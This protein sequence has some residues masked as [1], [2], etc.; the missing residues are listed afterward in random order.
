[1]ARYGI[2]RGR[3]ARGDVFR[4]HP[5]PRP[6]RGR[7]RG[8]RCT[9]RCLPLR[10]FENRVYE[11]ELEDER[12]L[13]VKF[14]RPGRWSRETIL[15]EHA[16][17]AD[18]ADA[19]V[20]AVAPIDLGTGA[21]LSEIEGIFY[22]AFPKVRGRSLDEARRRRIA[23]GSA[24]RSAAC[25]RSAPRATR[26]AARGSTSKRYILEPLEVLMAG[27]FIPRRSRRATAMSPSGS[28]TAAVRPLAAARVQRIHGDLHW[29]NILWT[30][31]SAPGRLRRLSGRPARPG[32]LAPGARQF[33][34]GA[35]AR[36]RSAG[37]L[38]ALPR[39]RPLD[40][41][42][43]RAATRDAHRLHVGLDRATVERSVVSP[44]S[45]CSATTTTGTRSTRSS[46]RSRRGSPRANRARSAPGGQ[47]VDRVRPVMRTVSPGWAS[48]TTHCRAACDRAHSRTSGCRRS[49]ARSRLEM[50]FATVP[51]RRRSR[52]SR[53][54]PAAGAATGSGRVAPRAGTA[55]GRS[56][57]LEDRDDAR[58]ACLGRGDGRAWSFSPYVRSRRRPGCLASCRSPRSGWATTGNRAS[59][60]RHGRPV[61][62]ELDRHQR[63]G[64]GVL[65]VVQAGLWEIQGDVAAGV[66]QHAPGTRRPDAG[67][68]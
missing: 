62:A 64:G 59:E 34:G 22:A 60:A 4:A 26:R 23:G 25:T 52:R 20:P 35:E 50:S 30:P 36:E 6:G 18:L 10:A 11:V 61:E 27:D 53:S 65:E 42:P 51:P 56:R 49:A 58:G 24:E 9:G 15:D 7:G 21:T 43:V 2:R 66:S 31:G 37:G 45:R 33:R 55:P 1:M 39:V 54:G 63:R 19:E 41:R 32:P 16:F 38:R 44:P 5:R 68:P 67:D 3:G 12:R 40:A 29:G 48:L 17:L 47:V 8:L 57:G 13:V 46:C 14:Y 28:P